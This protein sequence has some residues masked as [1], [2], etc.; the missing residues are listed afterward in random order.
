MMKWYKESIVVS[1]RGKGLYPFTGQIQKIIENWGILEGI[2][3]LYVPHTSASLVISESYDPSAKIDLET[4]MEKLAPEGQP[5]HEH[6]LEGG[7][8]SPSH[9]RS[10]L[11]NTSISIPVDGGQLTL[12]TWQGIYLFEHRR[13][14]HSRKVHMRCLSVE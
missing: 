12:G 3:Y 13:R 5:W 2:C 6:T 10:M 4:F 11:T 7:D 1:T 8:D 9:M 14:G